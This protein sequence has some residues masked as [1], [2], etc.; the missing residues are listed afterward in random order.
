MKPLRSALLVTILMALGVTANAAPASRVYLLQP[1]WKSAPSRSEVDAAV[2]SKTKGLHEEVWA[3]VSCRLKADGS[4][5]ACDPVQ[6]VNTDGGIAASV[7]ALIP[8]FAAYVPNEVTVESE[9][10][11]VK[12]DFHFQPTNHPAATVELAAP[13][14]LQSVGSQQAAYAFPPAAAAAGYKSGFGVVS[15]DVV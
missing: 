12:I 1:A 5:T 10:V 11:F 2:L 15:P 6:G 13:E 8:K 3:S 9:P 14:L 4:L 7:L